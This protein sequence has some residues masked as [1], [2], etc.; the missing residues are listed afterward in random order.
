MK[1]RRVNSM[2]ENKFPTKDIFAFG[3]FGIIEVVGYSSNALGHKIV[4]RGRAEKERE[5]RQ[6]IAVESR[7]QY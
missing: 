2:E 1:L 3:K 7:I 4:R 5:D 6:F